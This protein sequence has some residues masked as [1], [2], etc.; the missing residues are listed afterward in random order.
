MI[1]PPCGK[2]GLTEEGNTKFIKSAEP[3][4]KGR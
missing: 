1:M 3:Q 2:S 4:K